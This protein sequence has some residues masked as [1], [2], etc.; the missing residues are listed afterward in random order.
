MSTNTDKI[1]GNESPTTRI[2]RP[3]LS[4]VPRV[5]KP[6]I[7]SAAD[8]ARVEKPVV[9]PL[10]GAPKKERKTDTVQLKVI[11]DA[12]TPTI[13]LRPPVP[14]KTTSMKPPM[15]RKPQIDPKGADGTAK[16]GGSADG[17]AKI[18]D[19]ATVTKTVKLKSPISAPKAAPSASAV[20]KTVKL[21][22]APKSIKPAQND[23]TVKMKAMP[24]MSTGTE[25]TEMSIVPPMPLEE[26]EESVGIFT[27]LI[28]LASVA[29]VSAALYFGYESLKAFDVF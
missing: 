14:T 16:I 19:A 9:N 15:P 5:E 23:K 11:K 4:E 10:G 21:K 29:C 26:N 18:S 24:D 13:Q 12:K 8:T 3:K 1:G 22:G 25:S 2:P 17:T 27:T 28:N 20:T 6:T 7:P